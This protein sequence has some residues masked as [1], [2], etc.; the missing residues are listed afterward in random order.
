MYAIYV[1]DALLFSTGLEDGAH[2]ILSPKVSLD[3]NAAGSL[4]FT[5]PPGHVLYDAIHKLKSII[6]VVQ[7]GEII[8]RGRVMDDTKD[9]YN[10]KN[11]YCEGDRSF[12]LDSLCAP[13]TY[14]GT[15]KGLLQKLISAHNEQVDAEKR[16]T[17]G[18][19]TVVSSS[20][21]LEVENT[22]YWDTLKEIDDKLL[23]AYGGY[24]KTRM[25][26]NTCYVDWLKQAGETNTQTIEFSVNLLDLKD[27]VDA[28]DV[29]TILIPLGASKISDSGEYSDPVNITSVNN[30]IKYI[31]DDDA[32]KRYGKIWRTRTWPNEENPAKLLEKGQEHL[33]TGVAV[34]TLT[35]N[36][37]DMHFIDSNAEAIRI[38]DYVRIVSDPHGLDITPI[39]SKL[40]IELENPENSTYTFGEPPKTLT[41]NY[42]KAEESLNE[43]TGGGGGGGG[44]SVQEELKDYIR[45]ADIRADEDE[46]LIELLT[47]EASLL[48]ERLSKAEITLDGV[49]A[50]IVLMA[51]KEEVDDLGKRV[52]A[53]EI[54]IDGANAEINL[55]ASQETVD[56]LTSRVSSAEIAIDGANAAIDLKASQETVDTLTG[57]VSTAEATLTVQAGQISSKVSKDGVISE[58]NQSAE[59]V[60]IKA[61]KINLSGY[62]TASQ[63]EAEIASIKITDSSYI[64]TAGLST[65]SM[66]ANYVDTNTLA[67]GG[68]QAKWKEIKVVT[69]TSL[70]KSYTTVPGGNGADYVVIGGVT[71]SEDKET[72]Y[73]LGH[74]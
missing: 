24:L 31:Q 9:F 27:K 45:W 17:I 52:S 26:G 69:D 3:I 34:Q 35:L 32:V 36:A 21:T 71:L 1:D 4:T 46:A 40:E 68:T 2:V 23:G 49:N 54:E 29:F 25:V 41:E 12:L 18:N 65:Q 53:A 43:L 55:K 11:F 30:G 39:C 15:I 58:I 13:Y 16:F 72:I 63:L 56:E 57:R 64:T 19:V 73:Y 28:S 8:F 7:D 6:T 38:G 47:G 70:T 48:G 10:Q 74:S 22:A 51:S 5:M 50:Q 60:V 61:S 67:V 33:K 59:S 66:D 62:V 37:V 44:K 20:E 14:K 42:I